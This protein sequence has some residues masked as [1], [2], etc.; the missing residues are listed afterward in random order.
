M[1]LAP[2]VIG[3]YKEDSAG[4]LMKTQFLAIHETFTVEEAIA[5]YRKHGKN[6][7]NIYYIYITG[8]NGLLKG[9]ISVRELLTAED[10]IRVQDIMIKQ[11]VS[12]TADVD[13]EAVAKIFEEK[14]LVS[15]PV[16]HQSQL[17]GLIDV[18]DI[19]DVVRKEATEDFHKMAPVTS[20][21][22]NLKTASIY[23][24]YKKRIPW[25]IILVFMNIFSGA[26]IA[27]FEDL[28]AT[29]V[30]LVFFL[31]LLIDSGGNAGSQ[32]STLMIRSMAVGDIKL[33]DWFKLFTK[34]VSIAFFLGITMALAVASIGWFRGGIDIA[35]IVAL[36]MAVIVMVGSLIGMSL[37]FIFS[38]LKL[39]P[40]TASAPL[41]TSIADICGVLI[42][43]SI[44]SAYL[45]L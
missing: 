11:V 28:I 45:N 33:R 20:F 23:T 12:V 13:Q 39:D 18:D 3:N 6:M 40:A 4:K 10:H 15:I 27:S 25:L 5:Y 41:I 34:E 44:A 17:V 21:A 31:P 26:G 19:L 2:V 7:T 30:A 14:D 32:A 38:K 22:Q 37:P 43:F 36:T 9:V 29:N 24:L 1:V 16:L 8:H 42:Y 35:V